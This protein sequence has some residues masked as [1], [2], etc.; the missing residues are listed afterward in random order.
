MQK[1]KLT[2]ASLIANAVK[3]IWDFGDPCAD[4]EKYKEMLE[5][6]P[7]ESMGHLAFPC[8]KLSR[9]LRN[10]PPKIAA[11]IAEQVSDDA[12][13][14]IAAVGGYLNFKVSSKALE[15]IL[16]DVEAKGEKYGSSGEGEGKTEDGRAHV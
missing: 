3:N 13:E 9:D 2:A 1:L 4:I 15:N 14:S 12:F 7:D 11:A 10:A 5:Y 16:A 6:P 8:F